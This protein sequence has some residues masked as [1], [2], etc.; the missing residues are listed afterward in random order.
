IA[1]EHKNDADGELLPNKGTGSPER[2]TV[3]TFQS[4]IGGLLWI[5]R[6]TRS[7]IAYT[8]YRVT[9]RAH[10]PNVSDW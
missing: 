8:M 3:Q 2:P 7:D 9:R 4:L 10:A 5:A 1:D 6:C